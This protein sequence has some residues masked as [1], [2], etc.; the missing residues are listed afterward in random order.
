MIL[1]FSP[2]FCPFDVVASFSAEGGAQSSEDKGPKS[3]TSLETDAADQEDI[4]SIGTNFTHAGNGWSLLS[5]L[6][7]SWVT[8]DTGD[9]D[10]TSFYQAGAQLGF[11][12]FTIGLAGEIINNYDDAF[13]SDTPTGLVVEPDSDLWSAQIGGNYAWDAWTVGLGWTHSQM[14]ITSSSDEDTIDYI[15]LNG[16]YALGP[17]IALEGNLGYVNYDDDDNAEQ[18]DYDA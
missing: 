4:F 14:E 1:Y 18:A 9:G 8:D 2:Q 11:G 15:S 12:A 17:G 13:Q 3:S 7:G 5:S 10:K 16:A 6:G